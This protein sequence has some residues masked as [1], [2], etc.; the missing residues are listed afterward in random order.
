[1]WL[2]LT[3][4]VMK[5]SQNLDLGHQPS[6]QSDIAQPY[7]ILNTAPEI[8]ERLKVKAKND[9][10]QIKQWWGEGC[11]KMPY[12]HGIDSETLPY[13][14][15]LSET[16]IGLPFHLRLSQHELSR[17]FSLVEYSLTT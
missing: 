4:K 12:F 16:S 6:L 11:H 1:M 9:G 2:A 13:T 3:E 15:Q 14:N 7:W 5:F 8:I 17:I 10:I